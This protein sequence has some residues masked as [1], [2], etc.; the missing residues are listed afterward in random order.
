MGSQK[1]QTRLS[2]YTTST[3]CISPTNADFD[4]LSVLLQT[5]KHFPAFLSYICIWFLGF[6]SACQGQCDGRGI[7]EAN[8]RVIILAVV[9][10][11]LEE[12]ISALNQAL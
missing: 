10:Q 9:E 2:D 4:H 12:N 1:S 7:Q 3:K 6:R 11:I 8:Q 5:L